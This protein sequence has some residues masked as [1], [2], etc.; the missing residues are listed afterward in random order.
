MNTD[1]HRWGGETRIARI[2][3]KPAGITAGKNAEKPKNAD[4]LSTEANEGNE[5]RQAGPAPIGE[6]Q[7][8]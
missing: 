8:Y 6:T 3:T 5:A 7:N 4:G 2:F 1:E